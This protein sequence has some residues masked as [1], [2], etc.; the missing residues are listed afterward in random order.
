M[1]GVLEIFEAVLIL[2][3]IVDVYFLFPYKDDKQ[4]VMK[5]PS[6]FITFSGEGLTQ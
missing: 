4:N 6:I 3:R 1:F 2:N 5:F